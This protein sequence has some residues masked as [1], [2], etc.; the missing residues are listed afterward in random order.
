MWFCGVE[1]LEG[2][3]ELGEDGGRKMGWVEG[4]LRVAGRKEGKKE[5]LSLLL[6]LF[7]SRLIYGKAKVLVL[8]AKY[9]FFLI[10]SG[11]MDERIGGR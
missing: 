11:G 4:K 3:E 2:S 5:W 6:S 7:L 9:V 1:G 10:G 8:E